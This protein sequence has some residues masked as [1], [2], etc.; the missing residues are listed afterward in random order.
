MNKR[1]VKTAGLTALSAVVL[2][3]GCGKINPN[4]TLVTINT[5]DGTKDTITL[6]YGN[7]VARYQ[8]AML[9]QYMLSYYGEGMWSS[10]M[11]GS[12]S[13]LQD[14]VKDGALDD[15]ESQYLTKVHAA[16]YSIELAEDQKKAITEAATKF[17]AENP[18]ETVET[19]GATQEIVEQ[20]LENRTYY[21]LVS[22]AAK[23]AADPDITEDDCWMRSF[24]YVLYDTTGKKGEDGSLTPYTDEE[25]AELKENAKKLAAAEDFDAEVE[26]QGVQTSTY[27]YLKGETEDEQMDMK[28]IEAAEKLKEGQVS[29]AIGVADV[30]YYVIRLDSDHDED[31]SL[32]KRQSLQSDAFNELMEKWKAEITWKVND[33]AWKKVEFNTLFKAP[34]AKTE[35]GAEATTEST[36]PAETTETT[37]EKSEESTE[38]TEETTQEDTSAEEQKTE[39][40]S[41]ENSDETTEETV[42][43]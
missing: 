8:Q 4:E 36:E 19:M 3:T 13:T 20:Y 43:E 38:V 25:V 23:K 18:E 6:G 7:F 17:I 21:T 40:T 16:D 29:S 1:M 11:S 22:D 14:E 34:E 33:K 41:E 37:E 39:E 31:A 35:E 27:S 15:M 30:G 9:D 12:G 5:A 10:D 2:M 32:N 28:L 24:T 26:A 42:A